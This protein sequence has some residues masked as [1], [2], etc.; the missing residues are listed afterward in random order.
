MGEMRTTYNTHTHGI[1]P[2]PVVPA[3]NQ[4]MM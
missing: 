3:P 2:G 1:P 4:R